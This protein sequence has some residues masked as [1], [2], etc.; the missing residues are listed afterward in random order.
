MNNVKSKINRF[1]RETAYLLVAL[2]K[3]ISIFLVLAFAFWF[4]AVQSL[5]WYLMP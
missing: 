5:E 4:L 3:A 1:F 2:T